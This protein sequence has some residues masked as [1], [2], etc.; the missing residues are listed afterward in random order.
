LFTAYLIAAIVMTLGVVE[1]HF[2]IASLFKCDISYL[3]R[4]AQSFCISRASCYP[5]KAV[6]ARVL[7]IQ[8]ASVCGLFVYVRVF[9]A[10]RYCIETAARIELVFT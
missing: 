8:P 5:N 6:L 1:G 7:A 2:P 4:V 9:V 3:W 10:R